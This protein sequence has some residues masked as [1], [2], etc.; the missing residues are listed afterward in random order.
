MNHKRKILH[1][2]HLPQVSSLHHLK[3]KNKKRLAF[4]EG[5]SFFKL[6]RKKYRHNIHFDQSY[7]SESLISKYDTL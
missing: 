4:P 6:F 2:R 7:R 5:H 3:N 1:F